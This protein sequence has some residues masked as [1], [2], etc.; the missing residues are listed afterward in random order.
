MS[1]SVTENDLPSLLNAAQGF[2]PG[3]K[4]AVYYFDGRPEII[5]VVGFTADLGELKRGIQSLQGHRIVDDSTNLYG[6]V[7]R[8]IDVL[9]ERK[10][11]RDQLYG[12][13]LT[14]FTDGTHQAGT[15]WPTLR[16][17]FGWDESPDGKPTTTAY[18][19]K[20]EVI[21]KARRSD[22]A[23]FTIGLG[24]EIDE[25]VLARIGREGFVS[26]A[27]VAGLPNA[28][29]R[30][31]DLQHSTYVVTYCSPRR[32]GRHRLKVAVEWEGMKGSYTHRYS[33]DGFS[34]TCR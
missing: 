9:D 5:Q 34:G 17:I 23:L 13:A 30:L 20:R 28:F 21:L 16:G 10:R 25:K 29:N 2:A 24:G 26:A 18:P 27:N 22:H 31:I 19:G 4:M 33:A 6:A 15:T 1:G 12:S 11:G 8:A 14:V 7:S 32:T 3:Q